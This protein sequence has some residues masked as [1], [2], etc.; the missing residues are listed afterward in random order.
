[1]LK[2][3]VYTTTVQ[4]P[5]VFNS[6]NVIDPQAHRMKR[7]IVGQVINEGGMRTFE[8]IMIE[9]IDIFLNLLR[10]SSD[11]NEP[12]NMSTHLDYLSCDIV[13]LLS[14]GYHLRLQTELENRFMMKG[15]YYGNYVSNTRMQY[16]R[17]YQL[18]LGAILHHLNGALRERYKRLLEKMITRRIADVDHSTHDLY[19]IA[20]RANND[21]SKPGES[22]RMSEIWS[23]AVVFF[24]AGMHYV[25]RHVLPDANDSCVRCIFRLYSHKCLVLLPVAGQGAHRETAERDSLKVQDSGRY[26]EWPTTGRLSLP[27]SMYR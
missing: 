27:S 5:G 17:L 8:P 13:G 4:S 24:P 19:A 7:K 11:N 12:V 9:Q 10:S 14:F 22:L 2:S 26:Q 25:V 15:M 1:M 6:F 20:S 18:K 21:A 3:H 16:F 23:E